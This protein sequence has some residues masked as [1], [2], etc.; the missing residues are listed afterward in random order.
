MPR[1][2]HELFDSLDKADLEARNGLLQ[3]DEVKSLVTQSV[4]GFKLTPDVLLRLQY[5]AIHD[6]YTCAGNFR[7]GPVYLYRADPDPNLHQPPPWEKVVPL[8]RK[9]VVRQHPLYNVG[10]S[11]DSLCNVATQFHSPVF[12]WKRTC[13]SRSLYYVLCARLGYYL[14]GSPT[15]PQQIADVPKN[16]DRYFRS[17][18]S[19]DS[20]RS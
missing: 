8:V 4:G 10:D 2:P 13:L 18:H 19:A 11:S 1:E 7:T 17:L 14:P 5:L 16:R 9:C 12:W 20:G 3:I 15:V 6:I